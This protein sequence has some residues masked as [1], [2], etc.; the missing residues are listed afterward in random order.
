MRRTK[1]VCTIGPACESEAA[2]R[3]MIQAGMDVARINFSHGTHAQHAGWVSRIRQLAEELGRN[4]AVLGDLSGPKLRTGT[5]SKSPVFLDPGD[6]FLL[7]TESIPG[8]WRGVSV[9]FAG[10]P[11][12]VK[13]GESIL[14]NDGAIELV[15]ESIVAGSVHTKVRVGGQLGSHKGINIPGRTL[16]ID[17]FTAKDRDDTRFALDQRLDWLALSFVRTS[18]DLRV[19]RAWMAES[20]APVP[21]LIAKIE[22]REAVLALDAVL[23][24][25]DGAMV[26]R[27]D[28]GVEVALEEVPF[29]Q[30]DI[31]TGAVSLSVPVII[32]THMLESMTTQPRPTRA[33]VT[34]VATAVL[35]GADAVMLSEETASGRYPVESVRMM[36]RIVE[37]AERA[38]D[39]GR[40]MTLPRRNQGVPGS[41]A[42]AACTLASEVGAAAILVP[43]W[44]GKTPL[45]V[46]SRRP[47]QP[48][49]ALAHDPRVRRRLALAW[50]TTALPVPE[51][52]NE[53]EVIATSVQAARNQGH[54]AAGQLAVIA[55]GTPRQQAGTTNL[56]EV[57]RVT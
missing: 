27:G 39:H 4:V 5:L 12:A 13:P 40:F 45:H 17:G 38:I 34:D 53:S 9:S 37:Y 25:S 51:V 29:L 44:S 8:D 23:A 20:G 33:E 46:A 21:P 57:V 28:L 24:E 32:A 41:V 55:Y 43:T 16:A 36:A 7:S 19:A 48:V 2:L 18:E 42:H 31:V 47:V 15:V 35:D 6:A 14:L 1:I 49:I 50:G 3:G 26:A 11:D 30:K 10:L 54:L 52:S 56:I 22:K